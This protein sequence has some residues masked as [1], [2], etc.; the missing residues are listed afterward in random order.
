MRHGRTA[1]RSSVTIIALL[2]VQWGLLGTWS[3]HPL[4][5]QPLRDQ[6]QGRA[7]ASVSAASP[8]PWMHQTVLLASE[9]PVLNPGKWGDKGH[10]VGCPCSREGAVGTW[11]VGNNRRPCDH[12]P[13]P[14]ASSGWY[15]DENIGELI[16]EV[17]AQARRVVPAAVVF[18]KLGTGWLRRLRAISLRYTGGRGR[19]EALGHSQGFLP[20]TVRLLQKGKGQAD[21]RTWDLLPRTTPPTTLHTTPP[22]NSAW[23]L[24]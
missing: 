21:E 17:L 7:H 22:V 6:A 19:G 24:S 1:G 2:S 18:D 12:L 5:R 13:P 3:H 14:C 4:L 11:S 8:C 9:A 20:V 15:G 16:F 10:C 23:G